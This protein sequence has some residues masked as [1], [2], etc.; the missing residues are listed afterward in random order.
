MTN[1]V[2]V[3]DFAKNIGDKHYIHDRYQVITIKF[4]KAQM[5]GTIQELTKWEID[6]LTCIIITPEYPWD[7]SYINDEL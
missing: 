5:Y 1:D 6:K 7:P 4:E 3:Y 2:A